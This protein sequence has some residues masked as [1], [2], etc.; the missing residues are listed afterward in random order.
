MV[1]TVLVS[2]LLCRPHC[3]D[4][5]APDCHCTIPKYPSVRIHRKDC[6]TADED[7][8]VHCETP[9][10]V[11]SLVHVSERE[12]LDR[13]LCPSCH[14]QYCSSPVTIPVRAYLDD[15]SLN[16][17]RENRWCYLIV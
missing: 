16:T 12:P 7:I 15:V 17:M 1:S 4:F 5:G 2:E 13:L 9:I 10:R 3:N 11:R 6:A 8:H 14:C